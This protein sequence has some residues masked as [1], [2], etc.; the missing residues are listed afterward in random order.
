MDWPKTIIDNEAILLYWY[1]LIC[2][3]GHGKI[4]VDIS[5]SAGNITIEPAPKI[6]DNEA[7]KTFEFGG[8]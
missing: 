5:Q 1:R 7:Q 4:T 6:R 3:S 8:G 2:K